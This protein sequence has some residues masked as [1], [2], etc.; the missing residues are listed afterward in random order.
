MRRRARRPASRRGRR[1]RRGCCRRR[2]ASPAS[3]TRCADRRHTALD[4][5]RLV[6]GRHDRRVTRT[7]EPTTLR[8]RRGRQS[9]AGADA[10]R[11]DRCRRCPPRRPG[12]W[13]SSP[14]SL[15]GLA[16]GLIGY[17]LVAPAVRRR[18]R[19][20]QRG[21]GALIGADRRR[22]RDEHRRRARAARHSASGAS[23]TT[24]AARR[25]DSRDVAGARRR[26]P[27]IAAPLAPRQPATLVRAG[28]RHGVADATPSRRPPTWSPS[29]TGPPSG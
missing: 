27:R 4:V 3:G 21:L 23:S 28:R 1:C 15:G 16:G 13:P 20:R 12:R 19:R 11:D 14:S 6:E 2:P 26:S 5:L 25:H 7:R 22:G 9:R 8:W 29:T 17:T 18:L 24:G 10:A